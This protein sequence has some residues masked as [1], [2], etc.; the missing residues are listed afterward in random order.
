MRS[1]DEHFRFGHRR[2]NIHQADLASDVDM[3][4]VW[5]LSVTLNT[6]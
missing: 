1:R 4:I 5:E 6:P 2:F 3:M